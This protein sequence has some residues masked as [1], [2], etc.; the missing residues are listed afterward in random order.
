MQTIIVILIIV[1]VVLSVALIYMACFAVRPKVHTLEYE[2]DYLKKI[3]FM[4]KESLAFENEYQVTTFDGQKLWV[5][6][7]P[8]DKENKHF[9]ILSHGYTSTRY[10]IYKYAAL[11]RKLGFN[12]VLYE[13]RGHGVN[14]RTTCSFGIK[15]SRDLMSVIEDT[16][17][18]Y[19]EDIHIGLHGESMGAGLQ[20]MALEHQPKVDFIVNDCGYSEIL[21][22]LRWKVKQGFHL[23]GWLA[24][25]ASLY[26]KLL[27]GYWFQDVRPI[28]R[29]R[30]NEIPI[31]FVHGTED[32]FTAHWHSEKMYEVNKGYKELHLFEG[33]DHA[34]CVVADTERYFKMMQAFV[35]RVYESDECHV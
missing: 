5:G 6:F 14:E 9:V 1:F 23:P 34:E 16:Y 10:G 8:G 24:D 19:G 31:C 29:L 4:Q 13:N 7:V 25:V 27:F 35:D 28:D 3:D 22:V 11:W 2:L 32:N 20:V 26:G 33:V 12:C 17:K 18:R 15:E 30:E 21:P